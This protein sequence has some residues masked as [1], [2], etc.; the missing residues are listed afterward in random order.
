MQNTLRNFI[1][2]MDFC[3]RRI[4]QLEPVEMDF[5][6]AVPRISVERV[7]ATEVVTTATL[8]M[9][10]MT[11]AICPMTI[12]IKVSLHVQVRDHIL[13]PRV[14]QSFSHTVVIIARA[15]HQRRDN[16]LS[17]ANISATRI[18]LPAA[19]TKKSTQWLL[20]PSLITTCVTKSQ[21]RSFD[22]IDAGTNYHQWGIDICR[23]YGR[24]TTR[25]LKKAKQSHVYTIQ[26]MPSY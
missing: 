20:L 11:I 18:T 21:G 22:S 15:S 8:M 1:L 5:S 9:S 6:A 2:E 12:L 10:Q 16:T 7:K 14:I 13:L 26:G 25:I 4:L 19:M 24:P 23:S 17:T 3:E